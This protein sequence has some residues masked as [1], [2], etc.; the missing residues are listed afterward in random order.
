MPSAYVAEWVLAHGR[1]LDTGSGIAILVVVMT[2]P[3]WFVKQ[4][5]S[6]RFGSYR[7]LDQL[8]APKA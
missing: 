6:G 3:L 8:V 5:F 1:W 4:N 7:L 2:C